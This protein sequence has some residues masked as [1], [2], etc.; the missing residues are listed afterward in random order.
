M[1]INVKQRI[2]TTSDAVQLLGVV[3]GTPETPG[4]VTVEQLKTYLGT[5]LESLKVT[6]L[7]AITAALGD[8]DSG[9]LGSIADSLAAA[10]AT[11][12]ATTV[13]TVET[14]ADIGDLGLV[15]INGEICME[16]E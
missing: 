2:Q 11:I 5:A 1:S 9:A 12:Q 14:A 3:P 15:V 7:A 4:Y 10:V 8:S 13:Q 6:C 16:E